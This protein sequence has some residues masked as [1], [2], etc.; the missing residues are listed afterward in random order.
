MS[1]SPASAAPA[2]PPTGPAVV[3]DRV[4]GETTVVDFNDPTTGRL[5]GAVT[6]AVYTP[7]PQAQRGRVPQPPVDEAQRSRFSSDYTEMVDSPPPPAP[8]P[9]DT[10]VAVAP[11]GGGQPTAVTLVPDA[12]GGS[13]AASDYRF[14]PGDRVYFARVRYAENGSTVSDVAS[15]DPRAG[16]S[17]LRAEAPYPAS[18]HPVVDGGAQVDDPLGEKSAEDVVGAFTLRGPG[19]D[20]GDGVAHRRA[21]SPTGR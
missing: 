2:R 8:S 21:P 18:A 20:V 16:V 3:S 1:G 7:G 6:Y 14:G 13:V 9:E 5:L 12:P 10:V 11:A 15:V 17:S 19:G 4:V